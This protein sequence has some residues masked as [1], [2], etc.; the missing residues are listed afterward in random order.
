MIYNSGPIIL[1]FITQLLTLNAYSQEFKLIPPFP[2]RTDSLVN[3][4]DIYT[5]V[6]QQPSFN[7]KNGKDFIESYLMYLQ[8]SLRYPSLDG[9]HGRVFVEC[10]VERDGT[11]NNIHVIKGI[12]DCPEYAEYN[13]EAIRLILHMPKWTPGEQAGNKV[14]VRIMLAVDF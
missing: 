6:E 7:Y 3:Q 9:C 10:I 5:I 1:I 13:K 11:L 8:D 12:S 14:R 2:E 4:E